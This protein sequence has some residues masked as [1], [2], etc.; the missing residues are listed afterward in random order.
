MHNYSNRVY[1]HGY[2][3]IFVYLQ[4][5]RKTNACVFCVMLCKFLHF[6]YFAMIDAIALTVYQ[7]YPKGFT[8]V[9]GIH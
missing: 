1:L 4:R 5:F 7:T 3:S 6:L 8:N 9:R 2:C